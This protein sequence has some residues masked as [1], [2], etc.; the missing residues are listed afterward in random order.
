MANRGRAVL[1]GRSHA[2]GC[3]PVHAHFIELPISHLLEEVLFLVLA[4][5]RWKVT[6]ARRPF[7]S[8]A[9]PPT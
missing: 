2:T 4:Q 7:N 9:H 8:A 6:E 1:N 3:V 5:Q